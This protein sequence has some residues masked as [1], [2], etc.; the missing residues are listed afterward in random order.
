[1]PRYVKGKQSAK[2]DQIIC[3]ILVLILILIPILILTLTLKL[4][5]AE[6][7]SV[8]DHSKTYTPRS[9]SNPGHWRSIIQA[10]SSIQHPASRQLPIVL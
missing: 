8:S 1:M 9:R 4:T 7:V 5:L 3:H 10:A 6:T 2:L